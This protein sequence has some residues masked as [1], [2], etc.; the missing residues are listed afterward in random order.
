M[1]NLYTKNEE[2]IKYDMD[3]NDKISVKNDT[4]AI[5]A[6]VIDL[7]AHTKHAN[8]HTD[9]LGNITEYLTHYSIVFS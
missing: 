3:K 4:N 5:I 9:S 6:P 8:I 2:K 7:I 1:E